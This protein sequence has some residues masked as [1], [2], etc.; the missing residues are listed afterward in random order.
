MG[1]SSL[2]YLYEFHK[3]CITIHLVGRLGGE[4]SLSIIFVSVC[5][6]WRLVILMLFLYIITVNRLQLSP[7]IRN[8]RHT[9]LCGT[10]FFN[11]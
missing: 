7:K 6:C 5:V 10:W 11:I 1:Q 2:I 3:Q 9:V 4:S 8:L